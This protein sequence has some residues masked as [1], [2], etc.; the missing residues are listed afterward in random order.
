MKYQV[1]TAVNNIEADT[2]LEAIEKFLNS[3][4][5]IMLEEQIQEGAKKRGH[6]FVR[7]LHGGS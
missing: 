5:V 6:E 2:R 4:V 7:K 1:W 3:T